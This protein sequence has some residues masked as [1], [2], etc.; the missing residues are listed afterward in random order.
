MT[1]LIKLLTAVGVLLAA[2]LLML[3]WILVVPRRFWVE[4]CK[5]DGLMVKMNIAF[6]KA[7]IY[8]LPKFV[9]KILH[10]KRGKREAKN[11][12]AT[13]D[14][15]KEKIQNPLKDLQISFDLVT[16][17]IQSAKVFMQKIFKALKF[18]DVSFTLPLYAGDVLATQKTYA[19][20]TTAFYSFSI[21]LQKHLQIYYKSPVF[22]ADFANRYSDAV[23]FYTKITASPILLLISGMYGFTKY[24]EITDNHQKLSDATT[25]ENKNG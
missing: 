1:L 21:F 2:V 25:K 14:N 3:L 10:P 17:I 24:K 19:T 16:Q 8:P 12:G 6:F 5:A 9:Y 4:Y 23:Y 13:V 7:R 20:V 15:Q 22:V 18:S 11:K